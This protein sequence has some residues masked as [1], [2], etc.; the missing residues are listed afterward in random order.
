[1]LAQ[2]ADMLKRRGYSQQNVLASAS[3][4]HAAPTS[5]YNFSTY[6]S[7]FMTINTPTDFDLQGT[8][9]PQLYAFMVNRLALAIR[10]ADD[11]LGPGAVG[12]GSGQIDDLTANRS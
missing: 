8:I 5:F 12:W 10:R 6:N 2:A 7:V 1:M 9:D 3:H 4:T 11:N